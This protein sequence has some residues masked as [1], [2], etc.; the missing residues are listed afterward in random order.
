MKLVIAIL[1]ALGLLLAVLFGTGFFERDKSDL[2]NGEGGKSVV[3]PDPIQAPRDDVMLSPEKQQFIWD[4][5]HVTFQLERR[6][7]KLFRT[8]LASRDRK[9]LRS[10][11]KDKFEGEAIGAADW[12]ET[13][14]APL[15]ERKRSS[16][17]AGQK[18][19]ADEIV[20]ALLDQLAWFESVERHKLRVLQID[21]VPEATWRC[22]VLIVLVGTG[23]D[24]PHVISESEHTVLFEI[25]DEDSIESAASIVGWTVESE[26]QRASATTLMKEITEEAGLARLDIPDNWKSR[27]RQPHW[28]QMGVEDYDLDGDPDIAIAT[29]RGRRIVLENKGGTFK[30]A[31]RALG[32]PVEYP[33]ASNAS[34]S[35]WFDY[36]N[37]GYPDLF[38]GTRLYHNE[39]G[40]S[41]TDVTIHANIKPTKGCISAAV[42]DYDCDGWLDIYLLNQI[43]PN[44]D[45][46]KSV[47]WVNDTESGVEN[48]LWRNLGNGGFALVTD[49]ANAGGGTRASHSAVWFFYNDDRYP[50]LYIANDFGKNV[51]LQNDGDG[52]FTDVSVASGTDGYSTSMGIA[53][54]DIDNNGHSDLYVSNMYSKMGRRI[55]GMVSGD[56]YPA[57]IY[58]Q[59][60]GSCAGNRLYL[61]TSDPTKFK[62]VSEGLHVNGV[63]WAWAPAMADLDNDGWLDLYATTGYMSADPER[64]DG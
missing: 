57:E 22:R 24:A 47:G 33:E 42:A 23:T 38:S 12:D 53:A 52:T 59:I 46:T 64:P 39:K 25:D 58:E 32:L 29:T 8:A 26:V 54:G 50:D 45:K 4:A 16:R 55:I 10:Y 17:G 41:F 30:H 20:Q 43:P 51:L 27:K 44:L 49:E 3:A 15:T 60:C 6:F 63:G 18:A 62:D 28:F 40:K 7:G 5:E 61:R 56:D 9:Q 11:F 21:R 37:D 14:Q 13:K 19:S 34:L 31:T 1:V 36:D 2:P 35:F 48:Q